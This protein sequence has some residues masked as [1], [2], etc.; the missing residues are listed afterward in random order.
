MKLFLIL[1]DCQSGLSPVWNSNEEPSTQMGRY[2]GFALAL[3]KQKH[4]QK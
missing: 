4:Y 1:M 3:P 2:S